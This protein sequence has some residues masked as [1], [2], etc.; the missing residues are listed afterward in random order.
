MRA[1]SART[2]GLVLA[3]GVALL[4]ATGVI[5]LSISTDDPAPKPKP[6]T[7][8][9]PPPDIKSAPGM[10][11]IPAGGS[12]F[13]ITIVD[14]KDPSRIAQEITAD[15]SEPLP[16]AV[17]RLTRPAAWVFLKNG[18]TVHVEAERGVATIPGTT[19]AARPQRAELEGRVRIRQYPALEGG[20]RPNPEIDPPDVTIETDSLRF[21]GVRNQIESPERFRASG[22]TLAGDEFSFAGIG[23]LATLNEGQERVEFLRVARQ[24][25]PLEV[26]PAARSP[27]PHALP[28]PPSAVASKP[29]PRGTTT[30]APTQRPHETWYHLATTGEVT[31]TRGAVVIN[32]AGGEGWLRLVDNSIPR[33]PRRTTSSYP[34]PISNQIAAMTMSAQPGATQQSGAFGLSGAPEAP[35]VIRWSG[36]LDIRALPEAPAQLKRDDVYLS[37]S[38]TATQP[39][40][41]LDSASGARAKGLAGEFAATTRVVT[42]RGGAGEHAEAELPGSGKAFAPV[43]IADLA[44]GLVR[45]PDGPGWLVASPFQASTRTVRWQQDAEFTFALTPSGDPSHLTGARMS[46][47]VVARD[48]DAFLRGN[49]MDASFE[50]GPGANPS[51]ASLTVIGQVSGSDGKDG[52][53][54]GEAL[55]VTFDQPAASASPQPGTVSIRGAASASRG[56]DRL[57]AD[58]IEAT[59]GSD[60]NAR[61]IVTHVEATRDVTYL[62]RDGLR[63]SA[64]R[65]L[66]DPVTSTATLTGRASVRNAE[67]VASGDEIRLD[68]TRRQVVIPTAG[69]IEHAVEATETEPAGM[70]TASWSRSMTYDDTTGLARCEGDANASLVRGDVS[71]DTLAADAV[72]LALDVTVPPARSPDDKP[73]PSRRLLRAEAH[74]TSDARAKVEARRYDLRTGT[75][76]LERLHYLEGVTIRADVATGTLDVP[77][78]GR[79]LALDRRRLEA[80]PGVSPGA[81]M[82]QAASISARGTAL[83]TWGGS[84]RLERVAGV[85]TLRDSVRMVHDRPSGQRTELECATLTARFVEHAAATASPQD[86][87]SG[88]L[89]SATASDGVWLRSNLKELRAAALVYDAVKE[90]IDAFSAPNSFVTVSDPSRPAPL[91]AASIRWDLGADRIDVLNTRPVTLPR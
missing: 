59:L 60:A 53:V 64:D 81:A 90:T 9:D 3:G 87:V 49:S 58:H 82:T 21:D 37:L 15:R 2:K 48:A 4:L 1:G 66:A 68:G 20:R 22:R 79:L 74:G 62:G 35:T 8:F 89:V 33:T 6:T 78:P 50:R 47:N 30:P 41:L 57:G 42:L 10:E 36:Q 72:D 19:G 29:V 14:P 11:T 28:S 26:R 91:Q 5:V 34:S 88:E 43:M 46:G 69:R 13:H 52:A 80:D 54:S 44:S 70:A 45:M 51:I 7:R 71:R 23:L 40:H 18:R 31:A 65:I 27:S 61:R 63:A 77:T 83:F 76:V 56:E 24:A 39:V 25:E 86:S 55:T 73:S 12:Q 38:G 17:F 32:A 75:P 67:G 16:D 85:A 84:L